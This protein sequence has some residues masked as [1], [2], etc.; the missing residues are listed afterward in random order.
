VILDKLWRLEWQIARTM[1]VHDRTIKRLKQRKA[2]SEEIEMEAQEASWDS[3]TIRDEIESIKSFHLIGRA[4]RL[5]LPTPRFKAVE[6]DEDETWERGITG[7]YY[8]SRAAQTELRSR[9]R[10]EKKEQR[11]VTAFWVKDVLVPALS[12]LI[13]ILGATAG[14]IAI[15]HKK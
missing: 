5:G 2:S 13:G 4:I 14:L 1:R 9:I 3:D 15:L 8:L 7:K 12:V 11:E 10:L 6:A